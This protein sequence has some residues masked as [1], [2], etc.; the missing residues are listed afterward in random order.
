MG[1]LRQ[2]FERRDVTVV[3]DELWRQLNASTIAGVPVTPEKALTFSAVFAAHK[4]LAESTAM[5]PLF[6][7][8]RLSPRG[9]E[10]ATT[11]RLY[12]VLHDVANP[13]MDAYLVRE[14]MTAHLAGWGRAHAKIDYNENGEITALWPIHPARVTTARDQQKQ[15]IFEVNMPDGQKKTYPAWQMFY[16]RGMSPDGINVYSPIGLQRQGIGLGLAAEQ[17]GATFFGNGATPQGVITMEKALKDDAYDRFKESWDET[18]GG[19]SN[20]NKVAILE[21]GMKYEKIGIPPDDAQFLQTRQF[22][23]EE[24][25]RWYRIPPT[26]LAMSDKA[27]TYASVE[28]F[29]LQFVI[30][31]LYPWLVRWEKSISMQ[32]LLE[33]ER[34]SY[35]A[36]HLMTA[37]LR[38][39]SAARN[40]AYATGRQWGWLSV[41][42]VREFENMNPIEGGDVYLTPANMINA[43]DPT[44]EPTKVQRAYM[45]VIIDAV[46]RILRREAND[47]RGGMQK[48]LIKRGAEEFST[49]LS[50]FYQEHKDF[51]VR[52]LQPAALGY[53]EMIADG[54]ANAVGQRVSESLQMFALRRAGQVQEQ[55]REALRET[56]PARGI[57]RII[58][59]WDS[60]Y[61]E[62]VARM[63]ISRQTA[64]ILSPAKEPEWMTN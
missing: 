14:V 61:V 63:E 36:E 45:P 62:R 6:L 16:L 28:A 44:K 59:G 50:D 3:G 37:I 46:Q 15:L 26:M 21:E 12:G 10:P 24:I 27:S 47:I 5:L 20:S 11:K 22:Q 7:L 30:Y 35:C 48:V 38:G 52:N 4:I 33:R 25:A 17:F 39:D 29:G 42:D 54:D 60:V 31:T 58:E 34:K 64:V 43:N 9:K 18:H 40:A 1:F 23:V 49:W 57:E 19:V 8:K 32:L 13:E 55:F 56:E 2:A 51:I 53:A 41:N